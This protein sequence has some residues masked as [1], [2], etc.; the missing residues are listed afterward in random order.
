[1][2]R[3]VMTPDACLISCVT[4]SRS[5]T[6]S[7]SKHVWESTKLD[8][9]TVSSSPMHSYCTQM[10]GSVRE[11]EANMEQLSLSQQ[12]ANRGIYL[13]CKVP[14]CRPVCG[15]ARHCP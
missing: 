14:C 8:G 2:L 9:A 11:L 10:H 7:D 13:L 1:V 6:R 15:F 3:L 12:Y 5:C 4:R